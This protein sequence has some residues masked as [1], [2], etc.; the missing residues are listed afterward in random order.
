[1]STKRAGWLIGAAAVATIL[2]TNH[3]EAG[4]TSQVVFHSALTQGPR[5]TLDQIVQDAANDGGQ[6]VRCDAM[7]H[8]ID[9]ESKEDMGDA[10]SGYYV[11]FPSEPKYKG[12]LQQYQQRIQNWM[13]NRTE[14][15]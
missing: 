3:Y 9:L 1:M 4:A 14:N 2:I 15:E 5:D 10:Q 8:C 11:V 12:K 7:Q 13:K 6:I